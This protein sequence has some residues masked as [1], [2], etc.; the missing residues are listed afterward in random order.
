ML[1][2]VRI[3]TVA[4]AAAVVSLSLCLD[5]QAQSVTLGQFQHPKSPKD[6]EVNKTYMLGAMDGVMAY[7]ISLEDK[8][9]CL[10]GPVGILTFDQATDVV[11]RWARKT[12]GSADM[13]LGRALMY[14]LREAYPC[15][16]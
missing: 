7:N 13:P 12:S 5:A 11:M 14:G 16:H 15:R 2:Y 10:P 8:L 6:L 3:A 9:F 1:R 4:A